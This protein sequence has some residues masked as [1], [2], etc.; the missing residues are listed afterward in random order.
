MLAPPQQFPGCIRCGCLHL[1]A[2]CTS[3]S[4]SW[5]LQIALAFLVFLQLA[6]FFTILAVGMWIDRVSFGAINSLAKH[7]RVYQ[8]T[9]IVLAVVSPSPTLSIRYTQKGVSDH[10]SM[11][12]ICMVLPL[13]LV[14]LL[15]AFGRAG[16]PSSERSNGLSSSSGCSTH[17]SS[18]F[19]QQCLQAPSTDTFSEP[20][21][22]SQVFLSL[23]T[24]S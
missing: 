6:A 18:P 1:K 2:Q 16:G 10:Y 19:G 17:S 7:I 24:Y 12:Y 14:R 4:G 20:G 21:H 9:F 23:A 22:S 3:L 5:H 13:F 15:T 11:D 8:A